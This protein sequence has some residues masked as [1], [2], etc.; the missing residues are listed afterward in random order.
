[1]LS[2]QAFADLCSTTKKTIIHYDKIGLLRPTSRR[3]Q[4]RLYKPGQ[5]LTFQKIILLKSFGLPLSQIKPYLSKKRALEKILTQQKTSLEKQKTILEK[6][7]QKA[8]EFTE[9]LK[10]GHLLISPKINPVSPYSFYGLKKIGRYVDI[11]NH[12]KQIFNL[13]GPGH[14]QQPGLTVFHDPYYS[15]DQTRMTTGVLAKEKNPKKI[16]NVNL[17]HVPK[18][19]AL[20]YTHSGPYSYM[21]YIWQFLDQYIK[22]N[23]LKRHPDLNCREIYQVGEFYKPDNPEDWVTVLQVPFS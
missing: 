23:K 18:H 7:I 14:S 17:I 6:R 10:K 15:P 4:N 12:Q 9:S 1:M 8:K 3:G 22:E 21:S 11:K 19:R 13:I 2:T 5:V 20:V 16:K